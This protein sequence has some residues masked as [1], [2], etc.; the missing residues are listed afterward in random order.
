MEERNRIEALC[1]LVVL[2]WM[3]FGGRVHRFIVVQLCLQRCWWRRNDNKTSLVLSPEYGW[4]VQQFQNYL[5]ANRTSFPHGH[6]CFHWPGQNHSDSGFI[7][8]LL[9]ITQWYVPSKHSVSRGLAAERNDKLSHPLCFLR[10]R[11]CLQWGFSLMLGQ[12]QRCWKQQRVWKE[13]FA[14]QRPDKR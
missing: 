13:R 14:L 2:H 8:K 9:E 3:I 5:M 4:S 6:F 11:Y 1:F 12:L 10:N 7:G